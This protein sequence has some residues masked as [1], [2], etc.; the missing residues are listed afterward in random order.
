[1]ASQTLDTSYFIS[2]VNA[3]IAATLRT[4]RWQRELAGQTLLF[5]IKL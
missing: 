3:L 2:E 5:H 1:M 4:A